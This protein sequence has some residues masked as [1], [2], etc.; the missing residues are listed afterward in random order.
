MS[1]ADCF[2]GL[3]DHFGFCNVRGIAFGFHPSSLQRFIPD[4]F[5]LLFGSTNPNI[6]KTR[7]NVIRASANSKF[8]VLFYK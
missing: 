8:M 2:D 3:L 4:F 1:P 5:E 6:A 7:H